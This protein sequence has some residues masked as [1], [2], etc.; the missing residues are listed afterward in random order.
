MK[1]KTKRQLGITQKIVFGNGA[2]VVLLC[3]VFGFLQWNMSAINQKSNEQADAILFSDK[4]KVAAS[5]FASIR[6]WQSAFA[7]NWENSALKNATQYKQDF[8]TTVNE[9]T[10][11][12][13]DAGRLVGDVESYFDLMLQSVDARVEGERLQA[14][15][16]ATTAQEKAKLIDEKLNEMLLESR[17]SALAAGNRVVETNHWTAKVMWACMLLAVCSSI[18]ISLFIGRWTSGFV[19]KAALQ[20]KHLSTVEL[21]NV[22]RRLR[23]SSDNTLTQASSANLVAGGL[24]DNAIRLSNAVSSFKSSIQEISSNTGQAVEVAREAVDVAQETKEAMHSLDSSC[25]A[26]GEV[27]QVINSVAQQTNLLALNATIEAARAGDAGKGFAVVANEVKELAKQTGVAT[28]DIAKR[29]ETITN[30]TEH[31]A[32]AIEKVDEIISQIN[33]SQGAISTA[34]Q[35]QSAVTAE[36]S[37]SVSEVASGTREI[38]SCISIV[39][40]AASETTENSQETQAKALSI[41][42]TAFDLLQIVGADA[43]ACTTNAS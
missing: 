13:P 35:E 22:S 2:F 27:V 36:I 7:L 16:M 29:I 30:D 23:E 12:R 26:I 37:N 18:G 5:N 32:R 14:N 34:V 33:S 43:R 4:C 8:L 31:A 42:E 39:A 25:A 1:N 11:K 41:E 38:A 9:I 3:L 28:K 20:L 19:R 6:Y 24:S 10:S 15:K 21:M 17:D 40:N